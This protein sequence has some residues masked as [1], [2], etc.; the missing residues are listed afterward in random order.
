VN[1]PLTKEQPLGEF[2]ARVLHIVIG[3]LCFA[4]SGWQ[5]FFADQFNPYAFGGFLIF[6]LCPLLVGLLGDRK[7]VLQLLFLGWV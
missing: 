1:L 2:A 4:V 5:L 3:V 7:T 6:G